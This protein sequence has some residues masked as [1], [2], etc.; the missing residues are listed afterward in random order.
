MARVQ[1]RDLLGREASGMSSQSLDHYVQRLARTL[2]SE[3]LIDPRIVDEAREHLVDAVEDGVER[4]LSVEAAESAA[5]AR[6]GDPDEL[7]EAFQ[8]VYRW[9]YLFW[10]FAKIAASVVA[11]V[12]VALLIQVAVSLRFQLQAEVL[13]L[14][15]GFARAAVRSVAVVLGLATAWEI[16]RRP[17]AI[18]R[19][20]MAVGAYATVGFLGQVLFAAGIEAFGP[21]TLLVCVGWLCSRLERRPAKLL[22]TFSMFVTAIFAIHR[23]LH[24]TISPANAAVAS[25]VL[26]AVWTST[27]TILSRCDQLFSMRSN[28]FF[29][30]PQD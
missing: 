5:F 18:R 28:F 1:P 6:F 13:Q 14:A 3:G 25:A 2:R 4:G 15:P 12:A 21:A 17:F 11:S 26:I 19:A 20:T 30:T 16:G 22:L 23:T 24:I 8:R 9:N 29:F 10:Y 27:I 7:T